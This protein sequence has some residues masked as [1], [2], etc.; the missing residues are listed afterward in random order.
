MQRTWANFVRFGYYYENNLISDN[1]KDKTKFLCN[2]NPSQNGE[3]EEPLDGV[4]EFLP[5]DSKNE[6]FMAINSDWE[7]RS[8]YTNVYYRALSILFY[9]I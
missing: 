8:D 4:P 9:L 5:Y 6:H 2:R 7:M 1:K 3:G